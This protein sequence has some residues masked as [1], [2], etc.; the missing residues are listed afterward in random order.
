MVQS[1]MRRQ[2]GAALSAMAASAVILSQSPYEVAG[3]YVV[4]SCQLTASFENRDRF[5]YGAPNTECSWPHSVPF[6]NWGVNSNAGSQYDGHQFDGWCHNPSRSDCSGTWYEWHS[7]RQEFPPPNCL[8][9]NAPGCGAQVT[10]S[11]SEVNTYA[12]FVVWDQ[13]VS[14]PSPDYQSGGCFDLEGWEF[15]SSGNF[16]SLY[17]IDPWDW[18]DFVQT[19]Y[20]PDTSA[21]L[22]C[23]DASD[24]S[25]S[26]DWKSVTGRDP[27]FGLNLETNALIRMTFRGSLYPREYVFP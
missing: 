15:T 4:Y 5:M 6:G 7:C 2:L 27:N 13:E 12:R 18:D 25:V 17:E 1:N 9:Y 26:T 3:Q 8:Y 21:V 24:C 10:T 19:L 14:E 23:S 11:P 20:Y 22:V 16:T